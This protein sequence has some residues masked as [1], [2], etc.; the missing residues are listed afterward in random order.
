[1]DTEARSVKRDT[2]S[3]LTHLRDDFSDEIPTEMVTSISPDNRK[4]VRKA[5]FAGVIAALDNALT[6]NL[7]PNEY[8]E[9]V[10]KFIESENERFEKESTTVKRT[11]EQDLNRA[12]SILDKVLGR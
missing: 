6:D 8:R 12:K 4:M 11:T 10:K 2:L 9:E 1:M 5:W 3:Q 7:I